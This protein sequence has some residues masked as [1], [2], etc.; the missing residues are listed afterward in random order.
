[1]AP[2]RENAFQKYWSKN[3]KALD[4]VLKCAGYN[5]YGN[6]IE[7]GW[8]KGTHGYWIQDNGNVVFCENI[9]PN[10]NKLK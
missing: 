4:L 3:W 9:L 2:N 10:F 6:G 5:H 8:Q 1:M 7:S